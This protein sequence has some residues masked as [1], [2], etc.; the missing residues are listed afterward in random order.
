MFLSIF[1]DVIPCGGF[2]G[3]VD[4]PGP[5][6]ITQV[7]NL[8][9]ESVLKFA[10]LLKYFDIFPGKLLIEFDIVLGWYEYRFV[11]LVFYFN[12]YVKMARFSHIFITKVDYF[13]VSQEASTEVAGDSWNRKI[14]Y[15]LHI[16]TNKHTPKHY[17]LQFS[18]NMTYFL[19]TEQGIA[20][21]P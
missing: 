6:L 1:I 3:Y 4:P 15:A 12:V 16:L 5:E 14:Y 2:S 10:L 17:S 9:D 8:V 18:Q 7:V 19:C 11:L 13:L 20:I 21:E